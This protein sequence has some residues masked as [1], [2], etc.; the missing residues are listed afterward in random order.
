MDYNVEISEENPTEVSFPLPELELGTNK[1]F[2]TAT[3]VDDTVTEVTEE[4]TSE[5]SPDD[6][7]IKIE[8]KEGSVDTAT[9]FAKTSDGIKT[10]LLNI[11]G[12]DYDVTLDQE[13]AKETTFDIPLVEGLNTITVKVITVNDFEKEEVK[14]IT[15]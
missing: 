9:V 12:Q 13:N 11:N 7:E 14:E 3:S 4:I 1:I 8:P 10:L 6:I 2:V 5:A 15:R